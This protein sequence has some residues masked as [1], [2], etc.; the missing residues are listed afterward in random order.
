MK[1]THA[2]GLVLTL[3]AIKPRRRAVQVAESGVRARP[4]GA[5]G[6]RPTRPSP[7][8]PAARGMKGGPFCFVMS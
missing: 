3:L 4:H 1:L 8:S 5:I 2:S 6:R 7:A